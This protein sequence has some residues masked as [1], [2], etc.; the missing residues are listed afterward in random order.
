MFQFGTE[1]LWKA[2]KTQ[3][4]D[5]ELNEKLKGSAKPK[6]HF[7]ENTSNLQAWLRYKLRLSYT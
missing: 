1:I 3:E 2:V 4:N 5:S 7:A 6:A